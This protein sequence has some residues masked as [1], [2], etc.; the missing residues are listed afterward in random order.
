MQLCLELFDVDEPTRFEYRK[1]FIS[2]EELD[3]HKNPGYRGEK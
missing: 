3:T 2:I 1:I